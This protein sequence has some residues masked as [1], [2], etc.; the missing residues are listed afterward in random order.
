[1]ETL[2]VFQRGFRSLDEFST[3]ILRF[4]EK[5]SKEISVI[6]KTRKYKEKHARKL[7]KLQQFRKFHESRAFRKVDV[8]EVF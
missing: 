7:G 6:Y 3:G 8:K 2:R 1:L 4:P 5:K